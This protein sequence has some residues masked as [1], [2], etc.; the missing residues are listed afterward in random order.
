VEMNWELYQVWYR[1]DS[2]S[3]WELFGKG[4]CSLSLAHAIAKSLPMA[5]VLKLGET[6]ENGGSDSKID[7]IGL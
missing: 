2:Y 5:K 4:G 7:T 6:P 1:L 3:G